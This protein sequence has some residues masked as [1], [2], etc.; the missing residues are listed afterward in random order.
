MGKNIKKD[1]EDINLDEKE[2]LMEDDNDLSDE[3]NK[4]NT[5]EN[6]ELEKYKNLSNEYLDKLQRSIAEFDNFR[7]RTTLEKTLI[8]ENGSKDCI[9]KLLPILDN[10]ER[11]IMS[12]KDE[13]KKTPIFKG[14]EMIFSQMLEAFTSMGVTE[15][16]GVGESFD[17]NIHNAVMHVDDDAFGENVVAEVLQKGYL[18]NDKVLRP[19]MVKVAN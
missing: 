1:E 5:K 19:S 8:Y 17:P 10:F 3:Q 12:T 7:K 15:I 18:Y 4:E 9:E 13:D 14:V 11:A 6:D 2:T 16:E